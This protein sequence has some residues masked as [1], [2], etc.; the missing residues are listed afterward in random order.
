VRVRVRACVPRC[1]V[2]HVCNRAKFSAQALRLCVY[3]FMRGAYFPQPAAPRGM[4]SHTPLLL[5][6]HS[7]LRHIFTMIRSQADI[8][9]AACTY[10]SY[11]LSEVP[12]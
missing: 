9:R 11:C 8:T 3:A 6:V 7:L 4:R 12:Q 2:S 5:Y 10:F 1:V